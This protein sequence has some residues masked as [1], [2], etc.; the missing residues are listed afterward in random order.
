[1]ALTIASLPV[2]AGAGLS[3]EFPHGAVQFSHVFLDSIESRAGD[4]ATRLY[5]LVVD[6]DH[7]YV[8]DDWVVRNKIG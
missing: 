2:L 1:M 3:D 5:N 8:A 4:P 7:T 6:G